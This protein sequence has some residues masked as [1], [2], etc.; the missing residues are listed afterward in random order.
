M[1]TGMT[2]PSLVRCRPSNERCPVADLAAEPVLVAGG[3]LGV[4]DVAGRQSQEFLARVAQEP[5][6]GRVGVED[7]AVEG[8]D[9][10]GVLDP[11]EQRPA[12]RSEATSAASVRFRSVTSWIVLRMPTIRPCSSRLYRSSIAT[13][14]RRPS[15]GD[16]ASARSGPSGCMP[17]IFSGNA[18][19]GLLAELRRD[20]VEDRPAEHLLARVAE[21]LALGPVDADDPALG[22]DLVV[23]DRGLVVEPAEPLLRLAERSSTCFR[24]VM[25]VTNA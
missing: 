18:S 16:A 5:A 7:P 17:A 6:R 22:V 8:V 24:S 2:R 20:E 25:S 21:H 10:D 3:E 11:L 4:V 13:T 23:A 19:T 9:E 1:S 12:R 15:R 14:S